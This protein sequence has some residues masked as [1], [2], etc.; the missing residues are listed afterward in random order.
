MQFF[1][2]ET[3]TS[4]RIRRRIDLMR[5]G[6][7]KSFETYLAYVSGKNGLEIGGPSGLF[8]RGGV[9]PLYEEIGSLDNCDFSKAT[10]W[11]KHGDMFNFSPRKRHGKTLFCDGSALVDVPDSTYDVLFS[12]HNLEHFANPIK[13]LK[14]WQRVLRPNGAL[15]L[16]L[17]N[18]RE[19]FDHL[20]APTSVDHMFDDF[21]RG[22]G[23]DDTTHLQEILEKHDL[24]RDV[25]A[26]SRQD[27]EKRS[28]ENFSY[29]CLHHHV[30]DENN[31]RELLSRVGFEVLAV[32]L[33]LPFHICILARVACRPLDGSR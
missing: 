26:G 2:R 20:R 27:F 33:A 17:P 23:E 32:D 10:V 5:Q 13:A 18:Y 21:E 22:T 24:K 8:K 3:S 4:Q 28:L 15:I 30:F 29:R 12:A 9:L 11:A 14:E 31:S 25:G 7:L 16:V 1:G 6:R 19:T